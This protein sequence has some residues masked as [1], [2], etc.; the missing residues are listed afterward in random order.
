MPITHL[1]R[2]AGPTHSPQ[3]YLAGS[4]HFA[5]L[6]VPALHMDTA[7]TQTQGPANTRP[8]FSPAIATTNFR[9]IRGRNATIKINNVL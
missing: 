5:L 7:A 1:F 9:L 3:I 6:C 4:T 8:L 2:L